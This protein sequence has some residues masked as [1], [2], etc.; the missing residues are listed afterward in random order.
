MELL[1]DSDNLVKI[2]A[3]QSVSV[4]IGKSGKTEAANFISEDQIKK[5]VMPAFIK[6]IE[7]ILEDEESTS[8][9]MAQFGHILHSFNQVFPKI[10]KDN[11]IHFAK[12]YGLC[13]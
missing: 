3:I 10:V 5:D 7:T 11:L 2:N 6:L 4:L 8:K 12:F 9:L 13:C 1:T